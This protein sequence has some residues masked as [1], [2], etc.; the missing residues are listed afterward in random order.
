M[1]RKG[2]E[3]I[4]EERQGFFKPLARNS[5]NYLKW[6]GGEWNGLDGNGQDRNGQEWRGF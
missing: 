3:W 5:K 6:K 4:G 1:E 2:R